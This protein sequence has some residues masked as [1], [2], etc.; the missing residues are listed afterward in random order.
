[1][2]KQKS[3]KV[4][5]VESQDDVTGGDVTGETNVQVAD[6]AKAINQISSA[7]QTL[8]VQ[9]SELAAVAYQ[10]GPPQLTNE[11]EFRENCTE[12]DDIVTGM[13]QHDRRYRTYDYISRWK[14]L[15][16]GQL[17]FVVNG[18]TH[19]LIFLK[20]LE[21]MFADAGVPD[22]KKVALAVACLRGTAS[23]WGQVKNSQFTSFD[24]FKEFF[25]NRYWGV[26]EERNLFF[27]IKFGK[28]VNGNMAEYFLKTLKEASFL[29]EQLEE[30]KLIEF[31]INHFPTEV[32]CGILNGGFQTVEAVE[33]HL[34]RLD[35]CYGE[36]SNRRR[37]NQERGQNSENRAAWRNAN[38]N[39]GG[40]NSSSNASRQDRNA[41]GSNDNDISTI[42]T[43][44]LDW[45]LEEDPGISACQINKLP[46]VKVTIG[47]LMTEALVDSGCQISS[48]SESYF[49]MLRT[50]AEVLPVFPVNGVTLYGA[51]TDRGRTAKCQ[52]LLEIKINSITFQVP[53]LVVPQLKRTLILGYDWIV[54]N[55]VTLGKTMKVVQDG[56]E[57][58]I[59]VTNELMSSDSV[60]IEETAIECH[61]RVQVKERIVYNELQIR[62]VVDRAELDDKN[63]KDE[64]YQV[65]LRNKEV[66]SEQ[67]GRIS[68]YE[69]KIKL[70]DES[71]FCLKSYPIPNS[72]KAAVKQQIEEMLQWEIIRAAPT[73][74]ISPLV[75]VA[76]KDGSVRVCLD[77]RHLNSKMVK[78]HIMPVNPEEFLYQFEE[79]TILSSID[80]T[81][82]Y[83]QIP[84]KESDQKYTGFLHEGI[85]YVFQVLPYGLSTSVSS[86][87]RG[88]NMIL[89]NEVSEYLIPYVDDLLI[90][91]ADQKSHLRHLESLLIKFKQHNVTVKLR[92]SKFV[93][94]SIKFL[95][96]IIS[97]TGTEMDPD[98]VKSIK[99][100]P[101][102]RNVKHLKS[103]L[104]L[105]SYDRRYCENFAALSV[106]LLKLLK[107]DHPWK[108]G[109]E[110]NE[111]FEK[112]K[113][114][115][116]GAIMQY[117]PNPQKPYYI[118]CD[119]SYYGIGGCLFQK[120][121]QGEC[122]IIAFCSRTLKGA[123]LNYGI[124]EKE[125]L[126]VL[127]C[128]RQWR[129]FVL[130]TKVTV[131]TDHK[132]LIFLKKCRLMNSRLTRWTL[133]LQEYDLEIVH[134]AGKDNVVADVLSRYPVDQGEEIEAASEEIEIFRMEVEKGGK[135]QISNL[136]RLAQDQQEDEYLGKIRKKVEEGS[137]RWFIIH[138]N[139][140]FKK[141]N[142]GY[143]I[144][145]PSK[146]T[147]D[148]IRDE[149]YHN[150]HFGYHKVYQALRKWYY[151][152]KMRTQVKEITRSCDLCQ[153]SKIS[154]GGRGPMASVIPDGINEL[155]C[156]DLMGPLPKSRGG[157]AYLFVAIDAFSKHVALY[158]MKRA[159]TQVLLNRIKLYVQDVGK[160][161]RILSDNGTQFRSNR[162]QQELSSLGI[163]VSYTSVYFPQGNM[164]ERINREIGRLLRSLCHHQHTKWAYVIPRVEELLNQ[165]VHESTGF[166]PNEV[167]W[168]QTRECPVKCIKFPENPV[169][170]PKDKVIMLAK[171]RL[172][173]KAQRRQQRHNQGRMEEY[174][175]GD[176]VYVRSHMQ[177]SAE[178]HQIKK[179]FL[180]FEGP[181]TVR[182][183]KGP[184][185][186]ELVDVNGQLKGTHNVVN[187][188][189]C[190]R[191][192]ECGI[193]G[194]GVEK[195]ANGFSTGG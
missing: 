123:E 88:L 63:F 138:E 157:V 152:K 103:F 102:P 79:G 159:T 153:R 176:W 20:K 141:E 183:K 68:I 67:P 109:V 96:H 84:I 134:C 54:E 163:H 41:G 135:K 8:Q 33:Q 144:C 85:S 150:G 116:A 78:E 160:P 74:Y 174:Q 50:Q 23:D 166:T 195:T 11:N 175:V 130:G 22:E 93:R 117:H 76:K 188:K 21:E 149:H 77:A 145:V 62:A 46:I 97:R 124:T 189:R 186:Y 100:F 18:S 148:I 136:R 28:F 180:L 112:I 60:V 91:S 2:S 44:H 82:S 151:W 115:F 94:S 15:G 185:A 17:T 164:T 133:Y 139:V 101:R 16:G 118:Q 127:Y 35:E 47:E 1:M 38:T 99:E 190:Y 165:V 83:W 111:A 167:H 140:L 147:T 58:E 169:M 66:F 182:A 7:L 45:L 156:V 26:E 92:K 32:K 89:G 87:I 42:F 105:C 10:S 121:P 69:H 3:K 25:L 193:V 168:H 31:L 122:Q 48:V 71:P 27:K 192:Q 55:N 142:D 155:V 52:T 29:S 4:R 36:M 34:K 107:K 171:Q 14:E 40:N 114:V 75:T 12:A 72:H 173:T 126:A 5:D 57:Y 128:L 137:T 158:T 106:P 132:S 39:S 81:C 119:S 24:K 162:W 56:V 90:F 19:P 13:R 125:A 80:L 86:F 43:E 146:H 30:K 104:G 49:N 120:S 131:I 110:Q 184:N 143:K 113:S 59:P 61:E 64:L 51:F 177:S 98:R 108:W 179:L 65:L 154:A 37:Q 73:E 6:L 53:C 178:D 95:G 181:F 70:R 129:V 9:V 194:T 172:L 161:K 187:I 170:P 191:E